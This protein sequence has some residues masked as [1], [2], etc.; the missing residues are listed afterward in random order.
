VKRQIP[1]IRPKQ[2]DLVYDSGF[3]D[4]QEQRK[5]FVT[6]QRFERFQAITTR[7]VDDMKKANLAT[8]TRSKGTNHESLLVL[9]KF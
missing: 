6:R 4:H 3:I 1:G 5:K 2:E 9:K 7:N 8:G